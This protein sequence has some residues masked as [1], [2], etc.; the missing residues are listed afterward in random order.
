MNATNLKIIALVSML[1]DHIGAVLFPQWIVL[2]IIGRLAFPIYAFLLV[3]GYF[4]T[5]DRIKYIK[6]LGIFALISEVPFDLAFQG[7]ILTF[8]HQN[9]FFTL[10]FGLLVLYFLDKAREKDFVLNGAIAFGI[11]FLSIIMRTDYSAFGIAMVLFFYSY[12]SSRLQAV[13]FVGGINVLFG[14]LQL[15]RP[16]QMAA[17][18]AGIPIYL[19]NGEKGP[20]INKYIFY[21]FYP[22]HLLV[23]FGIK[24]LF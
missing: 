15:P 12:R 21:A 11:V 3:E 4:H 16:L 5:K 2:R 7:Q 24:A 9:V 20:S 14:L 19:Y 22:V 6:R 8:D 18:F 23:L 13:A 1:I 10:A 17:A